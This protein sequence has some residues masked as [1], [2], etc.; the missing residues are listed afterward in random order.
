MRNHRRMCSESPGNAF[1]RQAGRT[2]VNYRHL[3]S[4]GRLSYS[5][6]GLVDVLLIHG[7]F[8]IE[9]VLVEDEALLDDGIRSCCV[10]VESGVAPSAAEIALAT[11]NRDFTVSVTDLRALD[12]KS[13]KILVLIPC[14]DHCNVGVA[15]CSALNEKDRQYRDL[16]ER[17]KFLEDQFAEIRKQQKA[18]LKIQVDMAEAAKKELAEYRAKDQVSL[19]FERTQRRMLLEKL[20]R[21]RKALEEKDAA[22]QADDI[23][24][25]RLQT[26]CEH[27]RS[28][29]AA[30]EELLAEEEDR[31]RCLMA[32]ART[33]LT[34]RW[35]VITLKEVDTDTDPDKIPTV[36]PPG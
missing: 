19:E 24:L 12:L 15:A 16:V 26:Q 9:G 3:S 30:A 35:L 2:R 1:T 23:L 28:Q 32:Q 21:A 11:D 29:R 7:A 14:I 13:S 8:V 20:A 33:E 4:D 18:A 22:I 31:K 36:T 27:L 34:I 6:S 25:E 17:Y 5:V 10:Q